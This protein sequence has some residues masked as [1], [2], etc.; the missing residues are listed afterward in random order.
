MTVIDMVKADLAMDASTITEAK[1]RPYTG[2]GKRYTPNQGQLDENAKPKPWVKYRDVELSDQDMARLDPGE[3]LND[4]IID[5]MLSLGKDIK[6]R[7][8]GARTRTAATASAAAAISPARTNA[9]HIFSCQG[10]SMLLRDTKMGLE[11]SEGHVSSRIT[12]KDVYNG[13]Q[14]AMFR[15][16][17]K[18]DLF[19]KDVIIFPYNDQFHWS[20]AAIVNL[21]ALDLTLK[22]YVIRKYKRKEA[23]FMDEFD[24]AAIVLMDSLNYHYL[25]DFQ[26][27][28]RYML[29]FE[30]IARKLPAIVESEQLDNES[31]NAIKADIAIKKVFSQGVNAWS[32][33][34]GKQ[35]NGYDCGCF[36]IRHALQLLD[37]DMERFKNEPYQQTLERMMPSPSQEEVNRDRQR[38]KDVLTEI[39]ALNEGSALNRVP[40]I[41]SG[42]SENAK[43]ALNELAKVQCSAAEQTQN[44]AERGLS[45]SISSNVGTP[46]GADAPT[47]QGRYED[48]KNRI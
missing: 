11:G 12:A 7:R 48:G 9:V 28:L 14:R 35:E 23:T 40:Q 30:W 1:Q 2:K 13:W 47:E 45:Q 36:A 39:G 38:I 32:I 10:L 33:T 34:C 31:V 4:S 46:A 24:H 6:A 25:S 19:E 27:H 8:N 29:Y 18:F 16:T 26:Y 17:K 15:W 42:L 20:I 3:W 5:V 21:S 37:V 43:K 41:I 22:E 44:R